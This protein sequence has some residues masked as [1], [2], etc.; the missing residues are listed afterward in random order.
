MAHPHSV[1]VLSLLSDPI[2][3]GQRVGKDKWGEDKS[4]DGSSPDVDDEDMI[5]RLR[6]MNKDANESDS[7]DD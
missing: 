6:R 4:Y 7:D 5:E 2:R 3:E 1:G